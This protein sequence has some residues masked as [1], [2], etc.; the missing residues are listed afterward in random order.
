MSAR[1]PYPPGRKR[2]R[3]NTRAGQ[4]IVVLIMVLVILFFIVLWNFDLHKI[5]AVKTISRN[6]GDA[7]A[8]AAA[9]WQGISL[10]LIGDLNVMH[11]LALSAQD[12]NAA[13]AAANAQARLCYVGP[14]IGFMA[15]QQAAKN[16]GIHQNPDFTA[17]LQEH[18]ARVRHDYGAPTGPNGEM[19]FPEPYPGCWIE[20]A[21]MLD[22]IAAEGVAAG[23]ENARYFTDYAGGHILL[24][25]GFYDAIAGR[26]WCWFYHHYPT[27]LADYHNFFPCWW[28]PL[29]FIRH[30]EYINSEIYGLGLVRQ[31][32]ALDW[33]VDRDTVERAAAERG[34][35]TG[36]T[37]EG[38][39]NVA[40]WYGYGGEWGPWSA[41]SLAGTDPFPATGPV[42][43]QYDY[44]GADAAVRIEAAASRLTP[45]AGGVAVTNGVTWTAAAKPFGFLNEADKPTQFGLVLPAFHNARLIPIDTSSAGSGGGYDLAWR[46][47]IEQHLPDYLQHGPH[48]SSCWYCRQLLTWEDSQ[49]R[50]DGVAWLSTNSW[51]CNVGGGVVAGGGAR[52]GH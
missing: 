16:N 17:M 40:V 32:A 48:S 20:Y 39:T 12:T 21:D 31:F 10:N 14:M 30:A 27:L 34:L 38:L 15:A 3:Q 19:L 7:A 5:V 28:P 24:D 51:Q 22:M 29:S 50:M 18:A 47:H 42:R 45:G 11:A 41:I 25:R 35:P 44:A 36:I 43:Q 2:G 46:R 6:A 1:R 37:P 26:T 8:V 33:L 13:D 49:F 23:P 9:R 52:R 4:V